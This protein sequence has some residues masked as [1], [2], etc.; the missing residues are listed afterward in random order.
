MI[1]LKKNQNIFRFVYEHTY[2]I[3]LNTVKT[4]IIDTYQYFMKLN[5]LPIQIMNIIIPN[6]I[7]RICSKQDKVSH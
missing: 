1:K 4:I 6:K 7:W 5:F 2:R 3:E